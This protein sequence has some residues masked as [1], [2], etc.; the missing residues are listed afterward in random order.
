MQKYPLANNDGSQTKIKRTSKNLTFNEN[1]YDSL[2]C[3]KLLFPIKNIYSNN[4][5]TL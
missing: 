3:Q 4:K 5:A 2:T 1:E